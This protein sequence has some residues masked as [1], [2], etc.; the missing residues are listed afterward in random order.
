MEKPVIAG[1]T[2]LNSAPL[3]YSFFRGSQRS[4]CH[5]VPNTSPATC[6]ELL[7]DGEVDAALIPAI[8]YQRIEGIALVSGVAVAAEREVRSVFLASL[9]SLEEMETVALDTS[10]RTSAAL[11]KIFFRHFL[12]RSVRYLPWVPDLDEMLRVADGALIIGDPALCIRFRRQDLRIYDYASLWYE[13]TGLPLVF[14]VW[15]VRCDRQHVVRTVSFEAARREG[16]E[17]I[18]EIIAAATREL[19]LPADYLQS[20]FARCVVYEL[21]EKKLVALDLFYDLAFELKLIP[22]RKE[23]KFLSG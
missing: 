18:P 23:L 7:R 5:F 13:F 1:S 8:E 3:C 6:A 9:K 4:L 12:K 17:H 21:D 19:E 14:A 10:S 2:Y 16:M 11:T 22:D 15:A 20:Y